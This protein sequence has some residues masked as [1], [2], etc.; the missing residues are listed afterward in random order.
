MIDFATLAA[1]CASICAQ[2]HVKTMD[3]LVQLE[4]CRAAYS[5]IGASYRKLWDSADQEYSI[6][7]L[8]FQRHADE[9]GR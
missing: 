1:L 9:C 4:A 3:E 2:G 6:G 8:K 7:Y 5:D